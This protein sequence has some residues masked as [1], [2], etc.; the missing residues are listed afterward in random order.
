[1]KKAKDNLSCAANFVVMG[2]ACAAH[3]QIAKG[4]LFFAAQVIYVCYMALAGINSLIGFATLGTNSQGFVYDE[5]LKRPV[6]V[7]GDN[8]ML[9]LL[10]GIVAIAATVFFIYLYAINIRLGFRARK[11]ALEGKPLP[12]FRDDL[13]TLWNDK[14]HKI[15][16]TF[17][18]LGLLLF[19]V[20]PLIFMI[21]MAFTNFDRTHQPPGNLFTWVG[22]DNFKEIFWS[23]PL[24]SQTFFKIL[25]WTMIWAAAATFT[26]YFGGMALAMLINKK[27]VRL[28]KMWRAFFVVTIAVPQF[29]SLLLMR[30]LLNDNGTLN[31]LLQNWGIIKEPI[32]F[33]TSDL[34]RVTVIVVNFWVGV[35]Y[36]LLITTGI[37]MNI[38]ADIYESARIDGAGPFLTFRKI[39]MPYMLYV[40][41]PYLI[42]QTAGNINN[43]NVIY[44]L[45]SGNPTTL[46]YYQAGKTDLLITWLYKQTVSWQDYK[47]ASAIGI[48]IFI[49]IAGM[50]LLSFNLFASRSKEEGFQ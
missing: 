39:T 16:L 32:R 19:T 17:P 41:A 13:K 22:F 24:K 11:S 48:I 40:T 7:A 42:T 28:K 43:F 25:G 50:S 38:P 47:L 5:A 30:Q 33:L 12:T 37:L 1:M 35:P 31:L 49:L 34:A 26:C 36:T 18:F 23:N 15:L 44:L 14:Y 10:F 2:S 9:F 6:L 3:G 27:G 21:C 29:V 45:T 20:L 4:L 46:D 8:S